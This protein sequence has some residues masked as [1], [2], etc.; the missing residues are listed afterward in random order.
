MSKE[1]K[2]KIRISICQTKAILGDFDKNLI[3][4]IEKI[5]NAIAQGN[6]IVFFPELSL[7]GYSL[8]DAV[9]EVAINDHDAKLEALKK[10]SLKISI[11]VGIVELDKRFEIFN[12]LLFSDVWL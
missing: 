9:N 3:T 2:S 6:D 8:K 12:T 5:E 4:H 10:L 1:L 11:I 7:T